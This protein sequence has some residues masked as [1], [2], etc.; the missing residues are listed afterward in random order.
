MY[1]HMTIHIHTLYIYIYIY[2]FIY[3][4]W[5]VGPAV[6][7]WTSMNA[8]LPRSMPLGMASFAG[9]IGWH[10]LSKATCL[11]RSR[12]LY[13]LFAVSRITISCRVRGRNLALEMNSF[14]TTLT[15]P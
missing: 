1:V 15:N 4:F 12:S 3:L 9:K 10:Y 5:R 14:Q 11:I 6:Q 13:P 2:L 8:L 7:P